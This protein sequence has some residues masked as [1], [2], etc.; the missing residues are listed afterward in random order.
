MT[1]IVTPTGRKVCSTPD[2]MPLRSVDTRFRAIP[3][4]RH[5][6]RDVEQPGVVVDA[7]EQQHPAG[8][9]DQA[10]RRQRPATD[11]ERFRGGLR[12]VMAGIACAR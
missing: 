12:I 3:G 9:E 5:G 10:E 11:E 8:D 6:E 4:D 1:P 2:A 7:D